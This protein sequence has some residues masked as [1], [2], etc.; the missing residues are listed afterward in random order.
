M[1]D[2]KIIKDKFHSSGDR[3]RDTDSTWKCNN[4]RRNNITKLDKNP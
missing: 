3:I 4:T 2:T 1:E